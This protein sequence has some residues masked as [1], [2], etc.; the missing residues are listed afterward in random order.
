M[1]QKQ[2]EIICKKLDKILG[3]LATQN[4][5]NVNKRISILKEIGLDSIEI[6]QITGIKNP[7]QMPGWN[8]KKMKKGTSSF[9][10]SS[11]RNESE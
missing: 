3:I 9:I 2:F 7:R 8:N 4:I 11:T 1:E 6:S 5:E 10:E